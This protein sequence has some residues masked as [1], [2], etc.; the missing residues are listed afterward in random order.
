MDEQTRK[1]W[2]RP[3]L[4]VVVRSGREE[5]VLETCKAANTSYHDPTPGATDQSCLQ[6]TPTCG[7]DCSGVN[8]S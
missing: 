7:S 6:G 3:E 5:A 2:N 8:L 4:I 1:A